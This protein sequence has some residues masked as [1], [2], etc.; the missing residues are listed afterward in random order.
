MISYFYSLCNILALNQRTTKRTSRLV[1]IH[2]LQIPLRTRFRNTCRKSSESELSTERDRLDVS[3]A[4]ADRPADSTL[5]LA[6]WNTCT[7][8]IN[9]KIKYTTQQRFQT[10]YATDAHPDLMTPSLK[11]KSQQ[12]AFVYKDPLIL[13]NNLFSSGIH[14]KMYEILSGKYYPSSW[15]YYWR[16]Y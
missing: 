2:H 8:D 11:L 1:W 14:K 3:A 9:S 10:V 13:W 12:Y 15:H 16:K 7:Q 5:S 6:V 4:R